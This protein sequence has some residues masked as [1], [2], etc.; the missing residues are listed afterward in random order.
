MVTSSPRLWPPTDST[1]NYRSVLSSEGVHFFQ[2]NP[3]EPSE[4]TESKDSNFRRDINVWLWITRGS[5]NRQ[6]V[7]H[8]AEPPSRQR[9][10]STSTLIPAC[11]KRRRK[12]CPLIL[13]VYIYDHR[14][15]TPQSTDPSSRQRGYNTST[16]VPPSR[17]RRRGGES[18]ISDETVTYGYESNATL[19]TDRLHYTLETRPLLRICKILK[20]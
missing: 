9:G 5:E 18:L 17:N 13:V 10:Q 4:A 11:S 7:L 3:C 2:C 6:I 19:T 14:Q 20:L 8:S 1:T 16:V 12:G 15:I